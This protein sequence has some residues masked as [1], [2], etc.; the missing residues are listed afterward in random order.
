MLVA[1]L[2][3]LDDGSDS[4]FHQSLGD[5]ININPDLLA[6]VLLPLLIFASAFSSSV[7]V[8][9]AELWQFLWLALPMALGGAML[10]A[11]FLQHALPLGFDWTTSLLLGA[12]VS[13]TDPIAVVAVLRELG[14]SEKLGTLI[15]GESLMNDGSA[16]VIFTV[17]LQ[18][19]QGKERSS[20]L[21]VAHGLRLACGGVVLGMAMGALACVALGRV[22]ND[23][24]T[25]ICI[26]LVVTYGAW[27]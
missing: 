17:M 2:W 1:E 15:E 25:E 20:G 22:V 12:I 18:E 14:V 10:S 3:H 24:L 8:M 4:E 26:F 27:L 16:Y 11:L 23:T 7:H 5:W 13:A 19:L 6:T 21:M 9:Q